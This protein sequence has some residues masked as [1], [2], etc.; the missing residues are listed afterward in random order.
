M[1]RTRFPSLS[2]SS[3]RCELPDRWHDCTNSASSAWRVSKTAGSS[4]SIVWTRM[5]LAAAAEASKE[6][7]GI[8]VSR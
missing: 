2:V 6:A 5:A 7:A 8:V 4:A 3:I 1:E